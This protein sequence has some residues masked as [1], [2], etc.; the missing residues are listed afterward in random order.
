M[1][2]FLYIKPG[3]VEAGTREPETDLEFLADDLRALGTNNLEAVNSP[4]RTAMKGNKIYYL[5]KIY[6]RFRTYNLA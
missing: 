2:G 3:A 5:S 1:R 6:A 4:A